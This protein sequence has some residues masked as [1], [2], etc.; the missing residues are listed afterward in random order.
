MHLLKLGTDALNETSL[1]YPKAVIEECCYKV[2]HVIH[3]RL[4][5]VYTRKNWFSCASI[6]PR[7]FL[8]N[9]HDCASLVSHDCA[10][11][12]LGIM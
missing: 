3:T 1:L 2:P 6:S 12:I 10:Y 7:Q 11:L 5:C 9:L 8:G 4:Q